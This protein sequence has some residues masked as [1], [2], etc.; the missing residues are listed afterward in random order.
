MKKIGK[1][2]VFS[3]DIERILRGSNA[4]DFDYEKKGIIIP[5]ASLFEALRIDFKNDVDKIFNNEVTILSEE[6]MLES[7]Y[8]VIKDVFGVYPH[9]LIG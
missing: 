1:G 9:C 7:S 2:I 8:S 3:N 4:L 6:E 5:N